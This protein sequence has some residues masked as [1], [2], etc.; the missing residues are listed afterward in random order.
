MEQGHGIREV[1]YEEED[2]GNNQNHYN[3]FRSNYDNRTGGGSH[4]ANRNSYLST[5]SA[6]E[7][8]DGG[9]STRTPSPAAS[10]RS[11]Q[12][13]ESTKSY[14][15][16]AAENDDLE[17]LK[18][19]LSFALG[20]D[21]KEPE[22]FPV[23]K[24]SHG[25]DDQ[26]ERERKGSKLSKEVSNST[27]QDDGSGAHSYAENIPL[28]NLSLSRTK[29]QPDSNSHIFD[30][31]QHPYQN[32]NSNNTSKA[33][34]FN[35]SV[36][37]DL[38]SGLLTAGSGGVSLKSHGSPK[39][40]PD[41]TFLTVPGEGDLVPPTTPSTKKFAEVFSRLSDRI[42]AKSQVAT[43]PV[44]KKA[45]LLPNLESAHNSIY[46]EGNL[47]DD[48]IASHFV[49]K[50]GGD[51]NSLLMAKTRSGNNSS[52][53]S[54]ELFQN[55]A[56]DGLGLYLDVQPTRD[57]NMPDTS[58]DAP[59]TP[60]GS[61]QP[62]GSA[63]SLLR[64]ESDSI[65]H[66]MNP[67]SS[68]R[69]DVTSASHSS[70]TRV[71]NLIEPSNMYLFGK[72]LKMFG[73]DSK[74][75]QFCFKILADSKTNSILL[76]LLLLQVAL[77]TYRQWNPI[78]MGGYY[79]HGNN[80][81]DYILMSIN[82]A[83]T[84]EVFAKIITHGLFDDRIMYE[85]CGL[86]Y[87]DSSVFSKSY[88][89][90][91]HSL[92]H[93]WGLNKLM[94]KANSTR[95]HIPD[96]F[97]AN[98]QPSELDVKEINLDETK[99][100]INP[101]DL[102]AQEIPDLRQK[103]MLSSHHD[104][105]NFS[106][107]FHGSKKSEKSASFSNSYQER[108]RD[109]EVRNGKK[110]VKANTFF[111]GPD[112]GQRQR[113]I[114]QL[115]LKRAFLRNSWNR[116]DFISMVTFWI[117]LLLS[118]NRYDVKHSI[119]IFRALSC[120][121]ILRFCNLT[122]GTSTI[123]GAVKLALPQLVDVALFILC[124]WVLFGI[125]GVQSFKSSLSRQCVWTNPDDSEDTYINEG[126]YCGSY[127]N[128]SNS[129]PMPYIQRDGTPSTVSKGY[130]CP[131]YSQCVSGQ[132]PYGGTLS[133]DNILQSMEI[134]F[135]IMSVNTFTDIMYYT[136]DSDNVAA[137][138]FYI[139]GAFMLTVWLM[140]VFIAV[141]VKSFNITRMENEQKKLENGGKEPEAGFRIFGSRTLGKKATNAISEGAQAISS[142][143]K[144]VDY[145]KNQSVF[146][147]NYYRFEFIWILLISIDLIVQCTRKYD[148]TDRRR[149]HLYRFECGF[150]ACFA[151]EIIIR[152]AAYLPNWRLFMAQK[153]NTFDLFLAIIT[154]IIVLGPVKVGLGQ[155]YYWLTCFQIMR[156]Y[157][158]VLFTNLTSSLW[159][160]II[161]NF[162]AIWDLT[163]FY[164]ILLFLV[165]IILARYFEGTIPLDEVT[166]FDNIPYP[167]HTVPNS[168]VALYIIT[169]T[170]N[171]TEVMYPL[172]QYAKNI[173]SR[174]YG[175]MMLIGW[176]F[177]SNSILLNIFIAVIA[178]ALEI[179]ESGKRKQQLI[180][181]IENMTTKLQSLDSDSGILIK[182]KN[183]LFK[184]NGVHQDLEKAVI[185]LLLS[186]TAVNDFLDDNEDEERNNENRD[187]DNERETNPVSPDNERTSSLAQKIRLPI[188]NFKFW[189]K[190]KASK[191][192]SMFE[193][194]F[195]DKNIVDHE[196]TNF[197]PA[198]F[199]KRII[200]DRNK[201]ILKQNKF[202]EENPRFNKVFYVLAPN[203][204]LRRF[205]QKIV[206]S[207][208][209]ERIDGVEP[210]KVVS[211]VFL[212]VMFLMSLSLV[213][214]A[215]Y[216]TPLYRN[217]LIAQSGIWNWSTYIECVFTFTFTVEFLIKII[218]DG[219]S[220]TP[221]AYLR[222]SWNLIDL[223]VLTSL[224]IETISFLKNDGNLSRIVRG[225]KALRALRLLTI[226]TTAKNN[227]HNTM[228]S[229]F[230]KIINAGIISL[231]LLFPFSIWGLNIF[232][233]R[234]GVCLDGT[235]TK[236]NCYN[237]YT[238][239]VFNWD[240][241]SPNIY[242]EPYLQF[243]SFSTSFATLF[244]IVSLEGW[245][246]LLG[247]VM[248]STGIGTPPQEFSTPINGVFVVLFN[249]V[250][251]I[252]IL[253]LFV[254]VIIVNYSK[255]TGRAYMTDDQISWY[256]VR[257]FLIQIKASKRKNLGDMNWLRRF[258]YK[259]TIEKS[260]IWK[261]YL[262]FILVLH[263]LALL[264]E[265]FP[266]IDGVMIFR[267]V[268]FVTS[269][270]SFGVN[271]IM[272]MIGQGFDSFFRNKWNIFYLLVSWGALICTIIGF[273]ISQQNIFI[274]IN[275]L[276][277]VG[278]LTFIIP[279]SNRLS[280]LLKF[281]SAS[282]PT[283]ISLSFTWM[284]VFLV[285][286]I[287]LNQIFGLTKIGPNGTD[288]LNLRSVPK[289]LIVLFRCSFGEGWNYIMVDYTLSTPFCTENDGEGTSDCG[290][291]QYAYILFVLWNVVSM[292]IFLN[293]FV[294]LI[295]DSFSYINNRSSYI[296]LIQREEIRKFKRHWQKFD[297]EGTGYIDPQ[298]L[299]KFLHRLD[300]ALSFHFYT[301]SL[302]IKQLCKKWFIRNNPF[303]PYD[304]T[305]RYDTIEETFE[306]MDVPK[307]RERRLVYER[308]IEEALMNMKIFGD[309]GIS[310]TRLILQLPLYIAFEEGQCLNLIDFLDRRLLLQKV[311]QKLKMK[312][313]YDIVSTYVVRWKYRKDQELRKR[314]INAGAGPSIF[315]SDETEN[316]FIDNYKGSEQNVEDFNALMFGSDDDDNN[317][318]FDGNMYIPKVPIHVYKSADMR[319]RSSP[320]KNQDADDTNNQNARPQ[321]FMKMPTNSANPATAGDLS[322]N[323]PF[324]PTF[325]ATSS[326]EDIA[327]SQKSDIS[328]SRNSYINVASIGEQLENTEWGEALRQVKSEHLSDD[329][330]EY[331]KNV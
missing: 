85:E 38:E 43:T 222:S 331:H 55:T 183:K 234:L 177:I 213:F 3:P 35:L 202:L 25:K 76:S 203:H 306:N 136:M 242:Q 163:L 272:L 159:V 259:L 130:T 225:L 156:F 81:A 271:A 120:L 206:K 12:N 310:F 165:S 232:N 316:P 169:S 188:S 209:G 107:E 256:E 321:L 14:I 138:L 245:V 250:S 258:S 106:E 319:H 281:A 270:F 1:P 223:I 123:L 298:D 135:V 243:N 16:Q 87:P 198:N 324:Y 127:L 9:F 233:G 132:N 21:D 237:E 13:P 41:T 82:I 174:A 278:I 40:N 235:S 302:E 218:A 10:R 330:R 2:D 66:Q 20:T 18:E 50:D 143:A 125:I 240:V 241:Y 62:N 134:V 221:N 301:G 141:I 160:K 308:F 179:S 214:T 45:P 244:E 294:S 23:Q 191:S 145:L 317:R 110:F 77:L 274:N 297:P 197:N 224:W 181:F 265:T 63:A 267:E 42:A 266:D 289:A 327:V 309:P 34:N 182:L 49:N 284:I 96:S 11:S 90:L 103:Y 36:N 94:P 68:S 144:R 207:S 15:S 142:H 275:K 288:N 186:G 97:Y 86:D 263:V 102:T 158:V 33:R 53:H 260:L 251:T 248:A 84:F 71:S 51:N 121:R 176:F 148:I 155:A 57:E 219:I 150:T 93:T 59:V 304:I 80:W 313:A 171:W 26:Q 72:T 190:E 167:M 280:Q 247:N 185:N 318:Q 98:Y 39:K 54:Q 111:I 108:R 151:L 137:C 89:Y 283:L 193:N 210:H 199:A 56:S 300:G 124:F 112:K 216:L 95:Q 178:H 6:R 172:Q 196:L 146:L 194:P 175:S 268:I 320:K 205:C 166:D 180:Q 27:F 236:S 58:S 5:A 303:D 328:S 329:E 195:Y 19:G 30:K 147:K 100:T 305:V 119:F 249:F 91:S 69:K 67:F 24:S 139:F 99:N 7:E 149:T 140:N 131:I 64:G 114:D 273:F 228:I 285:F 73:P 230:G 173:S 254:S 229:G 257:K 118:I 129:A 79:Y 157:R 44:A 8:R 292:Y 208:Y 46:D 162:K 113:Q 88:K 296:K 264:I 311:E 238:N 70:K 326:V 37:T 184:K 315:V 154:S 252:F 312:R 211:E 104:G 217:E 101:F 32:V 105:V 75:R 299:P 47:A 83:Y 161:K 246:D 48:D 115:Q 201:L 153:R 286:A 322:P 220:F 78:K 74:I 307:I 200:T 29:S 295:L 239:T 126:Q 253:T 291:K 227:F 212:V 277:L 187:D 189:I 226:S 4:Q 279:R 109:A 28:A 164:F 117:S 152:F 262:N 22:W 31:R 122:T 325:Y 314:G 290:N 17:A 204:P 261:V 170:E 168:F 282:L 293:M 287:A 52:R 60:S 231:C 269:S 92:Q 133:Y 65:L 323:N 116:I 215:C 128:I 61:L 255:S 276:F 192:V